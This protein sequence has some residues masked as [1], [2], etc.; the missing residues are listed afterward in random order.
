VFPEYYINCKSKKL[1][2]I[3]I[4]AWYGI[5]VGALVFQLFTPPPGKLTEK[6]MQLLSA[7]K[8]TMR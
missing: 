5:G 7:T 6:P 8:E 4:T 2:K 1:K 3:V